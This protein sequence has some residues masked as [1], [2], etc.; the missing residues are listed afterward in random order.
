MFLEIAVT[1]V[2]VLAA[3]YILYRNLKGK[4][5]GKCDCCSTTNCPYHNT[6]KKS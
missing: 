4:S 2:I 3:G 6:K 1:A 5:K